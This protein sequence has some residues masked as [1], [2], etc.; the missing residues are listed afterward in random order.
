[1]GYYIL[2]IIIFLLLIVFISDLLRQ[3]RDSD[4]REN[5]DSDEYY[6]RLSSQYP[7]TYSYR[8]EFSEDYIDREIEVEEGKTNDMGVEPIYQNVEQ[9]A[10]EQRIN[11][12]NNE[13]NDVL[14]E[15]QDHDRQRR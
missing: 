2:G 4:T 11:E 15:N 12:A 8:E 5:F 9:Q 3:A 1:M 6:D 13:L 14:P 10:F 7:G